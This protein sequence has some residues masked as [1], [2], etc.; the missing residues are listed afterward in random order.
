MLRKWYLHWKVDRKGNVSAAC[1]YKFE[2]SVR[3]VSIRAESVR[4][5]WSLGGVG[6][7]RYSKYTAQSND[8]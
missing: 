8:R 6:V 7:S 3:W 5:R 4:G 1:M 2:S